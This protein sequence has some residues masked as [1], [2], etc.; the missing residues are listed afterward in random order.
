[1]KL[2]VVIVNYRTAQLTI[3]CLKSLEPELARIP[4]A[5]AVVTDNDS[6]DGSV[7]K[8]SAAIE[9]NHWEA[10]CD[11]MPLAKNG[12]FAW[13]NNQAIAPYLNSPDPGRR[14]EFVYLLNPDTI[15]LPDA[16][17]ALLDFLED[18]PR[19]G[20]AGGR[21]VNSDGSVRNSAF[22]FH[23]VLSEF[24]GALRLGVAS[25]LLRRWVVA[26]P[27]PDVPEIVDWVAGASMMIRRELFERIGL[28]DERYFMYFEETDFCLR[29]ARADWTCCYVPASRIV[30]LV[31]QSSGVTA[32]DRAIR[33]RPKY[34]FDSRHRFFR[35]HY[36][37]LKT[38][39]ADTLWTVGFA[40][41]ALLNKLRGKPRTDP[42]WLLWDFI[43]YNF[44]SWGHRP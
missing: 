16:I 20:I 22:R 17:T 6:Q 40:V 37:P 27:P 33:R 29:A 14:P 4:D 43:R 24:E 23:T 36:G 31:G 41:N 39:A 44:T 32:A 8:I 3:D 42:P 19:V 7:F 2:L 28:L 30:H 12:G 38:I 35:L 11:L 13:G 25:R 10:W 26:S 15:V 34:W 1:M 9:A 21:A 5:R 18:H